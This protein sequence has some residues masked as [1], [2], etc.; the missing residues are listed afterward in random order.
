[1]TGIIGCEESQEVTIQF[2]NLGHEFFSCDLQ[3]CSGRHPEWHIKG[4]IF[5]TLCDVKYSLGFDFGGF[6]PPCTYL[7]NSGVSWLYNKDGTKNK[8]RWEKMEEGALFFRSLLN[9]NCSMLYVENPIIHKYALRI[10]GVKPTQ[11]IQPWQFGHGETKAT[12]LWLKG[13][14]ELRP[15]N[16][17]SGREQ[18]L[19]KL[20]PSPERAKL[21]SKTYPGIARAMAE[22]WT[23]SS[24]VQKYLFI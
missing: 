17:V 23:K 13:L 4:D 24:Y 2:R 3:E 8:D 9:A 21:R 6:H 11:I 16:I 1:M 14:P 10:I 12:C 7:S 15:T 5:H 18:R 19:Q 22:Q 20:P